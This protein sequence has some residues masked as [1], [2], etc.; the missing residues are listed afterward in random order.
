MA[1]PSNAPSHISLGGQFEARAK[2]TGAG[3]VGSAEGQSSDFSDMRGYVVL[4]K[5]RLIG[6]VN[7][8]AP[9]RW[10]ATHCGKRTAASGRQY[11]DPKEAAKWV[12][13]KHR[14]F[15]RGIVA[16]TLTFMTTTLLLM[17]LDWKFT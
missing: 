17:F 14:R 9:D 11:S 7:E 16:V 3:A 10:E 2:A 12:V 13:Y 6:F 5:G 15:E 1:K 8:E 4:K